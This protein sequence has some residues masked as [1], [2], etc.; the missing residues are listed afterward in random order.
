VIGGFAAL[1][2]AVCLVAVIGYASI[3]ALRQRVRKLE[4]EPAHVVTL[5]EAAAYAEAVRKVLKVGAP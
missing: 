3:R 2:F 4:D 5:S 1:A